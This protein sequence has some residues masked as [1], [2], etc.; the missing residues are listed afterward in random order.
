MPP[1]VRFMLRH[2]ALGF[3]L[4][5]TFA[6]IIVATDALH[7]RSLAMATPMG[8]LGLA[9]FCFL[10]GLT[11]GSLQ[12]GFAVMLQGNDEQAGHGGGHG[13]RLVPIPVRVDRRRR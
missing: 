1:L 8:W 4:G 13:A 6:A 11:I 5:V 7:L 2:A 12:I 10:T 3:A 9:V